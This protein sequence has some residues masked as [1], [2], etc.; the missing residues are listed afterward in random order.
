[1]T[2]VFFA[3]HVI[4]GMLLLGPITTAASLFPRY[5][6]R[7]LNGPPPVEPPPD[8][9]GDLEVLRLLGRTTRA[10]G[11]VGLA[12]PALGVITANR[13]EVFGQVWLWVAIGLTLLAALVLSAVVIPAQQRVLSSLSNGDHAGNVG[14]LSRTVQTLAM[15]TGAFGA[16]WVAVAALMVWKPG[17]PS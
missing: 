1:M 15:T 5:A 3:L 9:R 13:E 12:I 2:T 14:Q 8:V 16:L 4:A 11:I 17:A 10:Y 7:C 6:R